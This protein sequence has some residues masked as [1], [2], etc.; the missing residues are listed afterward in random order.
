MAYQ[1]L[2]EIKAVLLR[3]KNINSQILFTILGDP[4]MHR[5][6]SAHPRT[7]QRLS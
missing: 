7:A 4:A 2:L 3:E 6:P 5:A 1:L